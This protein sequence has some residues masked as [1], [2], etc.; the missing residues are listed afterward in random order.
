MRWFFLCGA[1]HVLALV[2]HVRAETRYALIIGSNR[3]PVGKQSLRYA[4]RDARKVYDALIELGRV[5]KENTILVFDPSKQK[6]SDSVL[7]L[8]RR[9]QSHADKKTL[10]FYYSGHADSDALLLGS[11]RY[12]LKDLREQL[13]NVN[14]DL[15]IGVMDACQSGALT[16]QKGGKTV[17]SYDITWDAPQAVKGAVWISSSTAEEASIES[18]DIGGSVFSHYFVSAIRGAGDLNQDNRV[19]LEEAFRYAYYY[20]VSHSAGSR[21][22]TQHPSYRMDL[23]GEHEL[24]LSWLAIKEAALVFDQRTIGT[25]LVFDRNKNEV[26]AEVVKAPER[27]VKLVLA[28]GDYFLKKRLTNTILLTRIAL[29]QGELRTVRDEQMHTVPF[30]EDVTKGR[31]SP[32]FRPTWKYGAPPIRATAYTLRRGEI[33]LGVGY[34]TAIGVGDNV[35]IETLADPLSFF[36]RPTLATKVRLLSGPLTVAMKLTAAAEFAPRLRDPSTLSNLGVS[37]ETRAS[38]VLSSSFIVTGSLGYSINSGPSNTEN[39]FVGV[40]TYNFLVDFKPTLVD[41]TGAIER[42]WLTPNANLL[43]LLGEHDLLQTG[44]VVNVPTYISDALYSEMTREQFFVFYAHAWQMFHLGGG[45]TVQHA[46]RRWEV[47]PNL[48]LWWQF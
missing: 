28:P 8:A 16:A 11:E 14:V 48:A 10:I 7:Q 12:D 30:D 41:N 24:V 44:V 45:A 31:Y 20:T 2:S 32:A 25:Y 47:F 5:P 19:T 15:R 23:S 46:S 35:M 1:L 37:L 33:T 9:V 26:V 40:E 3:A 42:H 34:P 39:A 13:G 17:A 22:G 29:R 27:T 36:E 43:I 6:L 18:D 21:S 38:L 4:K